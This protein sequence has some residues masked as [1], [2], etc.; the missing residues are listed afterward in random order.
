M[1]QTL[2]SSHIG[3]PVPTT[4]L[5][6]RKHLINPP[7]TI[8]GRTLIG[9]QNMVESGVAKVSVNGDPHIYDRKTFPWAAEVEAGWKSIRDELDQVMKY[10]DQIPSFHEIM[11]EVS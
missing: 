11:K 9:L 3:A 8:T 4:D 6:T 10:R 5:R 2:D 7:K 1:E